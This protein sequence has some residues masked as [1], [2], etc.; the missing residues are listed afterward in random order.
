MQ[1]THDAWIDVWFE[2]IAP[3]GSIL[4]KQEAEENSPTYLFVSSERSEESFLRYARSFVPLGMTNLTSF[5]HGL[6]QSDDPVPRI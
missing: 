2:E 5:H 4:T 1:C 3:T 6:S